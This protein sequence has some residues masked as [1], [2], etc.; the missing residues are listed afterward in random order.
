MTFNRPLHT[1]EFEPLYH[2]WS[3]EIEWFRCEWPCTGEMLRTI[4]EYVRAIYFPY[5]PFEFR[6]IQSEQPGVAAT[7]Q[8]RLRE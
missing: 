7:F 5:I 1:S 2:S 4:L 3:A 8:T 6:N